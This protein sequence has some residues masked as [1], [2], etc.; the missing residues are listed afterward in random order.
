MKITVFGQEYH[1]HSG[2]LKFHSPYFRECLSDAGA[3]MTGSHFAYD[4][5]STE[6]DDG[7]WQLEPVSSVSILTPTGLDR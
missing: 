6:N 3:L 5:T 1:V 7:H 2:V 4:F